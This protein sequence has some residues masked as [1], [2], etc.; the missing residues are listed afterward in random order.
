MKRVLQLLA[1][2]TALSLVL[3]FALPASALQAGTKVPVGPASSSLKW[4]A[5]IIPA[6]Y[7]AV[8][9]SLPSGPDGDKS[10][11]GLTANGIDNW[12]I[13]CGKGPTAITASPFSCSQIHPRKPT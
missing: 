7:L 1:P 4:E 3:C 8:G 2:L 5:S 11:Y 6:D 10:G 9:D 12:Y 13:L